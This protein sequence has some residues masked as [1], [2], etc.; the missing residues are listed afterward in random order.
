MRQAAMSQP[1]GE[2]L[3]PNL[4]I[5]EVNPGNAQFVQPVLLDTLADILYDEGVEAGLRFSSHPVIQLQTTQEILPGKTRVRALHSQTD[6]AHTSTMETNDQDGAHTALLPVNAFLIVDGTHVF[7]LSQPVIN[8]GRRSDNNLVI[9]DARVSRTHAQMRLVNGRFMICDL[10]SSG[11]TWVNG[12][13]IHQI[14]LQAGDVI[15][16]SGV[17]LVF[18]QD[19][20]APGDTEKYRPPA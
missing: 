12:E 2:I 4:Y 1:G 8:I 13:R 6:L 11:G 5:I 19:A 20:N 17:P 15:S 16:L 9:D 18:G 7:P 3:A 10:D 14:I